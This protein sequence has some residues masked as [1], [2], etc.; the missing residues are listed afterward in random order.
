MRPGAWWGGPVSTNPTST[1][2][3]NWNWSDKTVSLE[4]TQALNKQQEMF[5]NLAKKQGFWICH[6]DGRLEGP[7]MQY[8]GY[9]YRDGKVWYLN[10]PWDIVMLSDCILTVDNEFRHSSIS[11]EK[12]RIARWREEHAKRLSRLQP[13]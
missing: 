6:D 8:R 13:M 9:F 4:E 11:W 12:E 1:S 3:S 5:L 2:S 7:V 10:V